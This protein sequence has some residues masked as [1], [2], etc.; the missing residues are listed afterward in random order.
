MIS[1]PETKAYRYDPYSKVFSREHYDH[2]SM[3]AARGEAIA[4]AAGAKSWGLIL[5][6]LGRQGSPKILEVNVPG[7]LL[8]PPPSLTLQVVIILRC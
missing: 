8:Y 6:T 5:G 1:N 3:L 2:S 7:R 4:V